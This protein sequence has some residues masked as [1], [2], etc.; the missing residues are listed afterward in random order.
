[1][2][3][4]FFYGW[5]V[6]AIAFVTMGVGVTARTTFSLV[7]PPLLAEFGWERGVTAG[8][9][10]FGFVASMFFN[11]TI[12][13]V[14]DRWGAPAVMVLG[15]VLTAMGLALAPLAREPWHLYVTLGVLVA[16]GTTCLGYTGHGLFL[17]NWFVKRRGM[18]TGIAFSGVG[19]GAFLI[20]PWVGAVVARAGWRAG[21]WTMAA[22]VVAIVVPLNLLQRAEPESMGLVADGGRRGGLA[23]GHHPANVVDPAW[24]ATTWTLRRAARTA[25]FWWLGVAYFTALFSWYAV[26]VHQT[27]Y[28]TELGFDPTLAAFAL[29]AVAMSGVVGQIALGHLSDRVGREWIW[30]I[31]CAG[32]VICYVALL[33]LRT[34]PTSGVLWL[35]VLSQGALGYGLTSVFG[36][37]PVEL[38]QGPH[39]GTIFGTIGALSVAGAGA[40]P[41]LTGALHDHT[42]TY[43]IAFTIAIACSVA[44][45]AAIWLAAPRKVRLVAGRLPRERTP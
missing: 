41:W 33:V 27:K 1:V 13:R 29:G 16:A 4:P 37:I 5:V 23:S 32:F 31:G 22:L 35:M 30:T 40:G 2:R 39:F 10:S 45:G 24:A 17:S 38:F 25:R 36:A 3:V 18:A 8:A 15:A 11:P 28:L 6:V 43:A 44:S 34:H 7:F 9:F 20:L 19:V 14:M 26:Q 12:G 21:C 42:G